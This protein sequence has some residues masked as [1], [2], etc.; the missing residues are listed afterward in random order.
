MLISWVWPVSASASCCS[1]Q[2]TQ[3][4]V[5][6]SL[7]AIQ[8]IR[9]SPSSTIPQNDAKLRRQTLT[10]SASLVGRSA[11]LDL[12]KAGQAFGGALQGAAAQALLLCRSRR[13]GARRQLKHQPP[14][15]EAD[16]DFQSL[17]VALVVPPDG[18]FRHA[19]QSRD[20]RCRNNPLAAVAA[21]ASGGVPP[22]Q[23][24]R[25]CLI[26]PPSPATWCQD[27][28]DGHGPYACPRPQ[29]AARGRAVEL[30]CAHPSPTAE[31]CS[32]APSSFP[33]SR[34]PA[35]APLR[36][37]KTSSISS[38]V[39]P[40]I[41]QDHALCRRADNFTGRPVPGYDAP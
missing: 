39:D 19:A 1:R 28:D 17:D 36:C 6:L 33:L 20:P 26:S 41:E 37:R 4:S 40:S 30:S 25:K 34:D 14:T 35:Q 2:R 23:A 32:S 11:Q 38:D 18:I 15:R 16:V 27:G 22:V 10:D 9:P 24:P 5:W 3:L 12:D 21:E 31:A 13:A 8:A 29:Q 7:S